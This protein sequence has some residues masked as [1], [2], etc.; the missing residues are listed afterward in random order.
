MLHRVISYYLIDL[1]TCMSGDKQF[2][3]LKNHREN[4]KQILRATANMI[5]SP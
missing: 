3:F 5:L 4:S 2:L 1:K